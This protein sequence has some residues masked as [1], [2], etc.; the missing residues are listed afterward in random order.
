MSQFFFHSPVKA[1]F[2]FNA[3]ENFSTLLAPYRRIC[4]VSGRK[5]IESTGFKKY[6]NEHFKTK[7]IFY[8]NQIEENPSINTII[9]G[10]KFARENKAEVIIG[11]GGGSPL[12]A[13]KAIAAFA[14]NNKGF[15]E[16]LST[17]RL[18]NE[19]LPL[20]AVPTTCGTG[21]E[22][23]NF[24]IITDTEKVDKINFAKE[25]TF[26][27]YAVID[28]VFLRSLDKKILYATAFDAITHAMEGFLSNRANPFSD[29]MAVTSMEIIMATFAD[30]AEPSRDETLVNFLYGSSL[31][32]I[33]ILHTGTT[34]LHALGYWLT[35]EKKIHHGTANT[36]LLPYFMEMLREKGVPRYDVVASL[37]GKH[38]LDISRWQNEMG[39]DVS[40]K[41]ILS[42]EEIETMT[43]YALTKKNCDFNPFEVKKDF[44][45][46]VLTKY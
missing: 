17:D 36:I 30:G 41:D 12:D 32:G 7:D 38:G 5:S 8:F 11:F 40:L 25:N 18:E 10:G 9:R 29:S 2:G 31:A 21:S 16:L 43:D 15:Y 20:I 19:P 1:F 34:L 24:A 39:Y 22:M 4:V 46:S 3:I 37:M 45:L 44:V 35:N 13:S 28:P 42:A 33:T 27:K 14:A 6:L 26:P 23:N